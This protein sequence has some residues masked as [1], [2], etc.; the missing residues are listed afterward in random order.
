M[1]GRHQRRGRIVTALAERRQERVVLKRVCVRMI[2]AS[3]GAKL[4][5]NLDLAVHLAVDDLD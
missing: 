3:K 4:A 5:V 2:G 1:S